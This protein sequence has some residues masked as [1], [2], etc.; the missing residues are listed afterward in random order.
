MEIFWKTIAYY[1]ANTWIWQIVLVLAGILST[2]LLIRRPSPKTKL[3]MKIYLIVLYAWIAIIYYAVYCEERRYNN[4][5][6][7]YWG[8]MAL[9]W[10]WD[11]FSDYT[12]FERTRKYDLLAYVFV[13][14]PFVYPL[15][16]LS[17]GLSFPMMT[18][19]IMPSTVAIFTISILL[20]FSRK[21]NI[22]LVLFL[23]HWSI[24]GLTKTYFFH[25]PE[26]FLAAGATI[27]AL[28]LFFRDYFLEDI[29]EDTKPQAKYIN[30]ILI[31]MCTTL[32]VILI[33]TLFMEMMSESI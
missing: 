22:L 26:D 23:C 16:S 25:I 11:A 6:A 12:P 19:P 18:L 24:I 15:F 8:V 14:L 10:L 5:M 32:G 27:P 28:Y 1:N 29:N 3:L 2:V 21:V 20:L 7:I 30:W 31:L 33:G 13:I 4:V 17:R 9:I